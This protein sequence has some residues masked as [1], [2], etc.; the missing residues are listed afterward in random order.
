MKNRRVAGIFLAFLFA[1]FAFSQSKTTGAPSGVIANAANGT[2][3]P[4]AHVDPFTQGERTT[5]P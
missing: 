4:T 5:T 1:S 3:R 2:G